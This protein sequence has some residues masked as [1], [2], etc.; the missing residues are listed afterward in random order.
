MKTAFHCSFAVSIFLLLVALTRLF[1]LNL[2][3]LVQIPQAVANVSVSV[4]IV[5]LGGLALSFALLGICLWTMSAILVVRN[6][7]LKKLARQKFLAI[8]ASHESGHAVV[9]CR[10]FGAD[11]IL[12]LSIVPGVGNRGY[13]RIAW[14]MKA[15]VDR[16]TVLVAGAV[17]QRLFHPDSEFFGQDDYRRALV[18]ARECGMLDARDVEDF[19][20]QCESRAQKIIAD[21]WR[22]TQL[23][24]RELLKTGT[25]SGAQLRRILSESRGKIT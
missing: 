6:Q 15:Y 10:L 2:L 19:I 14:D 18:S 11:S 16:A 12:E 22:L 1:Q 7:V 25:L 17:S 9:A 21:N 23:L 3:A 20:R 24:S 4:E 8:A 13:L 5:F